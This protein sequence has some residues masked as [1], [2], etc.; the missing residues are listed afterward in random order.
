MI[1][2]K[3]ICFRH[4]RAS[5]PMLLLP[6]SKKVLLFVFHNYDFH[7]NTKFSEEFGNQK[8]RFPCIQMN[9]LVIDVAFW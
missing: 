3:R 6:Q 4:I 2:Q 9:F 8:Y 1:N 7:Q 5:I